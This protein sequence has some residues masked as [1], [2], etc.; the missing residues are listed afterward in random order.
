MLPRNL[1][2]DPQGKLGDVTT[3]KN[4][5][6]EH[7]NKGAVR[8]DEGD[9][10]KRKRAMNRRVFTLAKKLDSLVQRKGAEILHAT[11]PPRYDVVLTVPSSRRDT[12]ESQAPLSRNAPPPLKRSH[13]SC[14]CCSQMRLSEIQRVLYN[15]AIER[16]Q[17][18]KVFSFSHTLRRVFDHPAML[19]LHDR[20]NAGKTKPAAAAKRAMGALEPGDLDTLP[21]DDAALPPRWWDTVWQT[22][23]MAREELIDPL[24]SGKVSPFQFPHLPFLLRHHPVSYPLLYLHELL[25]VH[26]GRCDS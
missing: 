6:V 26:T 20:A 16:G 3:F 7:I 17:S 23:G 4:L 9:D 22:A 15:E 8:Y 12:T 24:L 18:K 11:L 13:P 21:V 25:H 10:D 1:A 2:L 19:L 5:F 14:P